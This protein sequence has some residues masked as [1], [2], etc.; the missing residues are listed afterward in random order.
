M[1]QVQNVALPSTQSALTFNIIQYYFSGKE[2]EKS[3][4]A[5]LSLR[6][7]PFYKLLEEGHGS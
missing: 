2:T 6:I 4:G 7:T 3:L 5:P 1:Q